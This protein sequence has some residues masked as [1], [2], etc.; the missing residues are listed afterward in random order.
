MRDPQICRP[1]P[2]FRHQIPMPEDRVAPARICVSRSHPG[3]QHGPDTIT[4]ELNLAQVL[5]TVAERV[6]ADTTHALTLREAG[7][8]PVQYIPL[9]DVDASLVNR[10]TT[11]R[12]APYKGDASYQGVPIGGMKSVNAAWDL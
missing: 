10:L 9:S 3:G 12:A 7:Y 1:F 4:I 6:V 5:V 8:P 2:T 11:S